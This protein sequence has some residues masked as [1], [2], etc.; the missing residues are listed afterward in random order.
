LKPQTNEEHP[1][2]TSLTSL[3][4][5]SPRAMAV[6]VRLTTGSSPSTSS[7]SSHDMRHTIHQSHASRARTTLIAIH[8][9]RSLL[10]FNLPQ[11]VFVWDMDLFFIIIWSPIFNLHSST[12]TIRQWQSSS[13]A[14]RLKTLVESLF[15]L[16]CES[17][18]IEPIICWIWSI[19][20]SHQNDWE[21]IPGRMVVSF[22]RRFWFQFWLLLV[23]DW[24]A[25]EP[26]PQLSS[27]RGNRLFCGLES[28]GNDTGSSF[29]FKC[30]CLRVELYSLLTTIGISSRPGLS[31]TL[32]DNKTR[33]QSANFAQQNH[34]DR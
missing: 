8:D 31:P 4:T 6:D 14:G 18:F 7:G 24:R 10:N 5:S 23:S 21:P 30:G 12:M 20:V 28:S 29:L 17:F 9:A 16:N 26:Q 13:T 15:S 25:I 3:S 34:V 2:W 11:V 19:F 33:Q 22:R 32:Q 27:K 1:P